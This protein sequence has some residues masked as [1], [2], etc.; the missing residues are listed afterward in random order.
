MIVLAAWRNTR[1]P[2]FKERGQTG[3]RMST[4]LVV[5]ADAPMGSF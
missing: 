5:M 2:P 3:G 4:I 1:S